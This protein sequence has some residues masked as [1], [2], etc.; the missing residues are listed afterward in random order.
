MCVKTVFR[1]VFMM[2]MSIDW[3]KTV[4]TIYLIFAASLNTQWHTI[5]PNSMNPG[6]ECV[7]IQAQGLHDE[8]THTLSF[9]KHTST[10]HMLFE[11]GA[12]NRRDDP[13]RSR[14]H[15][16]M[17]K[18]Y[19]THLCDVTSQDKARM[20]TLKICPHHPILPLSFCLSLSF[21]TTAQNSLRFCI[22]TMK[23]S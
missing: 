1:S 11:D 19:I 20:I 8:M 9:K 5:T 13:S 18:H 4:P 17:A 14:W 10:H 15:M 21:L 2:S 22:L 6:S 7:I 3:L 16:D 12:D 23:I